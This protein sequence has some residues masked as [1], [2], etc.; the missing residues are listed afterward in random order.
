MRNDEQQMSATP[1]AA[2][3]PANPAPMPESPADAPAREPD[4]VRLATGAAAPD[5]HVPTPASASD[6]MDAADAAD[7]ADAGA[8]AGPAAGVSAPAPTV[9]QVKAALRRVK[10]PELNLNIV[11]L[12]LVYEISVEGTEV[13]V[14]MSLTSP[15]CPSGPEIM[16]DV[17]TQVKAMPGVT[18]GTVNLVW[19]PI[20]TPDRIEPRVRSYLGF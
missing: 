8:A 9:D 10:D 7:A 3:R 20:W 14:D 16:K 19:S 12:G 1:D 11:D 17:E 13:I 4:D 15:G 2:A 6:A 5:G 18:E